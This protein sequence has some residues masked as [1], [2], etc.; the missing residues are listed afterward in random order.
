MS[1]RLLKA[2]EGSAITGYCVTDASKYVIFAEVT[3][4]KPKGLLKLFSA[5][6]DKTIIFKRPIEV[7]AEA[8][9]D[10][11]VLNKLAIIKVPVI[12]KD[13]VEKTDILVVNAGDGIQLMSL[14]QL[15]GLDGD[16]SIMAKWQLVH[17][18]DRILSFEAKAATNGLI[19]VWFC[20]RLGRV[21][22]IK[23]SLLSN[24]FH[25]Y[26]QLMEVSDDSLNYM[27]TGSEEHGSWEASLGP[28]KAV[29]M[30]CFDNS[31][32][33]LHDGTLERQS[34]LSFEHTNNNTLTSVAYVTVKRLTTT[35][36]NYYCGSVTNIGCIMYKRSTRGDWD[37]VHTFK[38]PMPKPESSPLLNCALSF[39]NVCEIT[40]VSGTECGMLCVWRYDYKAELELAADNIKVGGDDDLV[41]GVQ[42]LGNNRVYFLCNRSE[43]RYVDL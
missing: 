35:Y 38:R 20:T 27:A 10:E 40:I 16:S 32:Y 14:E 1:T 11:A 39:D 43:L 36:V 34:I 13:K 21:M 22:Q 26:Q 19:E 6:N 25:S 12:R 30:A 15:F 41:H 2:S 42:L 8:A 29:A 31:I 3:Y 33:W 23:Y 37:I 4:A 5:G 24:K 7:G 9:R 17:G 18:K 28:L